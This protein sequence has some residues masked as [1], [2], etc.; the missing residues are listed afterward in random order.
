MI[1]LGGVDLLFGHI[2]SA[3]LTFQGLGFTAGFYN[4]V[5]ILMSIIVAY[6]VF[7]VKMQHIINTAN[8]FLLPMLTQILQ[9]QPELKP[10]SGT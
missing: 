10:D 8:K 3:L 6:H 9:T 1:P 4:R 7:L 2:G 5:L